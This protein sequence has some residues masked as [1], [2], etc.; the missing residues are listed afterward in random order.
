MLND[1]A[2][3]DESGRPGGAADQADSPALEISNAVA[4]LHKEH[5]GRGPTNTRTTIDGDLIAVLLEGGYTRAEETL[6]AHDM[7][8]LVAATRIG[9]QDA[10]RTAF[11]DSVEEIVGRTVLSFMSANDLERGLR[12]EIFVLEPAQGLDPT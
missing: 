3:I 5:V 10:M 2:Y 4:R 12:V 7:A 9:L 1:S 8:E 11:I 6:G